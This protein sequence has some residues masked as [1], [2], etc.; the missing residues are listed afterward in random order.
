MILDQLGWG[1]FN[2]GPKEDVMVFGSY[3][4]LDYLG[5]PGGAW[6]PL[7]STLEVPREQSCIRDQ[8]ELYCIQASALT[9]AL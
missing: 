1:V 2:V 6:G 7:G 9:P 3:S 5:H 4:A 8:T